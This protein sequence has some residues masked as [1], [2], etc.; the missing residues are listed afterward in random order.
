[1]EAITRPSVLIALLLS[2][3]CGGG[4]ENVRV[5]TGGAGPRTTGGTHVSAAASEAFSDAVQAWR[6]SASAGWNQER[7]ESVAEKF[8]TAAEE[9]QG[10]RF[11]EAWF[12]AG[13]A[14]A[15][16]NQ[17]QGQAVAMFNKALEVNQNYAPARVQLGLIANREGRSGEAFSS[18]QRAIQGDAQSVEAYV[19]LA[20][21]QRQR[22]QGSDLQEAQQNLRRALAV[23]AQYVPAFNQL[24]L[25]YLDDAERNPQMLK[26]AN[27]VC[28]QATT[29]DPNYA[30]VYNTWGLIRVRE[31]NIVG[32]LANFERAFTLN[33]RFFEAYMNF[34]S[35][36]LSFRGYEDAKKAFSKAKG[37]SPRSYDARI[38]LG[39]ALRGLDQ[40]E[41]AEA[42]Y[43]GAREMDSGRPD[44]YFNLGLLYQDYKSGSI[45][46]F[47]RAKSYF[48]D[49]VSHA[50][51]RQAYGSMVEQAQ[52]R[53][54][55]IEET[56]QALREAAAIEQQAAQQ[57]G[58]GG[59]G[60]QPPPPAVPAGGRGQPPPPAVPA[61]GR[62][63]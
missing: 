54:R 45:P 21:L 9:N 40:I 29:I 35:I 61:T 24:A 63:R 26:L 55:N 14:Y 60:A 17:T 41:Q 6:Q 5:N 4:S 44:S 36:T 47:Q 59:G 22:A 52:Q 13:L 31:G 30:P 57:G 58:G 28:K 19:N 23:D 39:V 32:A 20:I 42:E 53:M 18:F 50:S 62:G 27:V 11:V 56:I 46:D 48:G 49:F 10:G 16:C 12:N 15:Q 1:M 25:L 33:D 37:L 3:G 43:N 34:G 7:C 8:K 51:G 38:G 2:A